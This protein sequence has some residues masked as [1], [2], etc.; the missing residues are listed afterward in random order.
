MGF[1]LVPKGFYSRVTDIR[2]EQLTA[3]G[4]TLLLA[5]LDNTLVP[6]KTP[7]PDRAIRDW[8]AQLQAGGVELLTGGT[9]CHLLLPDLRNTGT[10]GEQ[11][12]A[13]LGQMGIWVNTKGIPYDASTAPRGIRAGCTVLTQRGMGAAQMRQIAQLF[14]QAVAFG[15]NGYSREQLQLCRQQV[16]DLCHRFPLPC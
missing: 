14:C 9:D 10:D 16:L 2:P 15:E 5:D 12:T 1:S 6:Y 3:R 11:V 13:I 4:I 8:K 7:E